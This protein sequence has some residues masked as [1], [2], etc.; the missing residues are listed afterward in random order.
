M[1]QMSDS[2]RDAFLAEPRYAI[3]TTLRRD[4][5]PVSV[6]VWFDWDGRCVRMFTHEVTPKLKR[7]QNDARAS[8]LVANNVDEKEKWVAFDGEIAVRNDGGIELAEKL[9]G[10]YWDETPEHATALESWRHMK[11]GW[12]LLELT[13]K[14]IR[15]YVD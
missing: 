8:V 3:L 7:I 6:P 13:P 14:S 9:A 2:E 4:G 10:R 15:T 1:G 11:S 5:S 12:R